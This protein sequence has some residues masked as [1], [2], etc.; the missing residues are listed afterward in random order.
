MEVVLTCPL[1]HYHGLHLTRQIN[2][3]DIENIRSTIEKGCD[4]ITIIQRIGSYSERASVWEAIIKT[5]TTNYVVAIKTPNPHFYRPEEFA[6]D[7]I[8]LDYPNYFLQTF[9][10]KDCLISLEGQVRQV[11]FL[12]M[13]LAIGDLHQVLTNSEIT[14]DQLNDYILDVFDAE[15]KL[16]EL[17]LKHN[18]LH[19]RNVFIICVDNE[20]RAV[21]GDFGE[22]KKPQF[23]SSNF[24]DLLKFFTDLKEDIPVYMSN[25]KQKLQKYTV[26]T[27]SLFYKLEETNA[28]TE[29]ERNYL[30]AESIRTARDIWVNS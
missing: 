14:E 12:I 19:I 24:D 1:I 30:A 26:N 7:Q 22:A 16:A 27:R 18:D 4:N 9:A 23:V 2:L 10:Q 25:I 29:E 21:L 13:E 6:I 20:T 8:L 15:E 28:N 3:G 5:N 11:K 17:G